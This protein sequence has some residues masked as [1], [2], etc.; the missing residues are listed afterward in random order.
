MTREGN[1]LT[2]RKVASLAKAKE[3]GVVGDG[4]GLYLKDGASWVLRF[5]LQGRARRMGLG[6]LHTVSLAEARLRAREARQVLLEGKDPLN[7]KRDYITASRL[8]SARVLTFDQCAEDYIKAHSSAWKNAKHID[9]WR[10]TITT[11]ASPVIGK[12]PVGEIDTTLVLKVLRPI[13]HEIPETA[14]RLRGRIER[15]L[16][17]WSATQKISRDNP[18]RWRGHLDALLPARTKV[19]A[20]KH[21]SAVPVSEIGAFMQ[22][23]R[24]RQSLSAK[25]LEFCILTATR[26][27]ET[28]GMRWDE[29]EGNVWTIRASRMKASR[30]HR[31]PL[32][33]RAMAILASIPRNGSAMVFPLSNMAMLELLKGMN[34]NGYT[35]HGFRS[36]FR[37]WAGDQTS[38]AREVIEHA[39][40]HNL[41][42]KVEASYRRSDALE[43]RRWLME[44]WSKFCSAPVVSASVTSIGS[45]RG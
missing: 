8:E 5:M 14:S 32:S 3:E 16:S 40:A 10:A 23:L 28:I 26:T 4:H 36:T 43:K 37:D 11:Y 12:L 13:W 9:Q 20:V 1:K 7:M 38:F 24:E 41:P 35:V 30:P 15:I 6:P 19:R 44:A 21:H 42:N 2:A 45:L 34:G 22:M 29:V 18:A 31:V 27:N 39:L 25:A 17:Y 33:D